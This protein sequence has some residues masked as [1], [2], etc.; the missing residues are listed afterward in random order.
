M[1]NNILNEG[2][3]TLRKIYEE[4]KE[5]SQSELREKE[6]IAAEDNTEKA[7]LEK[8]K[9]V[10]KEITD[11]IRKRRDEIINTFD[12]EEDKLNGISKKISQKREKYRDGKVSERIQAETADFIEANK[13]IKAETKKLYKQGK[14]PVFF[15]TGL[16]YA[17]FMPGSIADF[18]YC[19]LTF[20][21]LFGGIPAIIWY[22]LPKPVS[23]YVIALIY[24][25]LIIVFGG[26]YMLVFSTSRTKYRDIVNAGNNARKR[27]R[28]NKKVIDKISKNI[29]KDKDDTQYGLEN[30]NAQLED[31]R[32]KL[33]DLAAKRKD[34]LKAFDESTKQAVTDEI[35]NAAQEEIDGYKSR[36]SE[37][38]VNL[39]GIRD[40]IKQKKIYIAENYEVFLGKEIVDTENLKALLKLSE[41]NQ[42]ATISELIELYKQPEVRN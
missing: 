19:I 7:L 34:A 3:D 21:I 5:L 25:G 24:V 36:L 18:L 32:I 42:T 28:N 13:Q 22:F 35:K 40:Y 29:K 38:T 37:L 14:T 9:S 41:K 39:S 30:Y 16:Y 27:I 26:I 6:L 23:T 31:I 2:R 10:A 33:E 12:A 1:A 15:N 17:L 4:V 20:V 8:E 11:T